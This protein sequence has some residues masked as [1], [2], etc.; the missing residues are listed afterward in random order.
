MRRFFQVLKQ[1]VEGEE[2]ATHHE[3]ELRARLTCG[4]GRYA[5]PSYRRSSRRPYAPSPHYLA[6]LTSELLRA[7][8]DESLIV[9]G[10]HCGP[11][12]KM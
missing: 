1:A 9:I 3:R 8:F 12:R 4:L 11:I 10:F 7:G 5:R 6:S 2:T